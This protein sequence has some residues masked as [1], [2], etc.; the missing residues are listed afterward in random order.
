MASN[1]SRLQVTIGGF[2][3]PLLTLNGSQVV[4]VV[5]HSFGGTTE[6]VLVAVDGSASNAYT[7]LAR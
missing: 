3:M 1:L 6:P 4:I 7:I 5:N 2:S